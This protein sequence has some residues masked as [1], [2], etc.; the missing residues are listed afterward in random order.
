MGETRGRVGP[1]SEKEGSRKRKRRAAT[2]KNS[3]SKSNTGAGEIQIKHACQNSWQLGQK[4]KDCSKSVNSFDTGAIF[5]PRL[6]HDLSR[7]TAGVSV[8]AL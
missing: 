7:N 4:N 5:L 6:G 3:G 1:V 8:Y 2:P